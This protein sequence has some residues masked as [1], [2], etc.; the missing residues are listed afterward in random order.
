MF[1]ELT[2]GAEFCGSCA[3]DCI[4][5]G[6]RLLHAHHIR[7]IM[8]LYALFQMLPLLLAAGIKQKHNLM[9]FKFCRR[10]ST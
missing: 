2:E 1:A 4:T 7:V 6:A 3:V 8:D 5:F 10:W 9:L